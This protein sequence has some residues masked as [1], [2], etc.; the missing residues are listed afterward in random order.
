MVSKHTNFRSD[1]IGLRALA[2]TLVMLAHFQIP[3]FGFGFIGV[4]IFFVISGFL[5]TRIL[6]RD[7]VSSNLKDPSKSFLSLTS[8][9]LRRI[10]RLLPAAFTV[11][12]LVNVV[13][14]FLLNSEARA[15]L[16]EN[17]KWSLLFFANV[18]FLRSE[19]DYFQQDSEPS[20]LLHFWSLSIEEQ[21]YFVWPLLFL[22]AASLNKFKFRKKYFRFNNRLL[23]LISVA[24]MASFAFLQV[25]FQTA[26]AEAYFSIFTRAWE[27]GVGGFFGVLAFHKR[28]E[29]V[30]SSLELYTPLIGSLVFSAFVMT[31]S[32][33][34]TYVAIPV[35]AT[36]FFL[37]AGQD[38]H[39]AKGRNIGH[40][41][42][43][44]K[45]VM[46]IGTISYSLYL[47]HWP[48]FVV[49][50]S[51][52]T[53]Y[54]TFARL[55]LIPISIF[56]A[57]LLW[58]FVEIPFQ[59]IPL[60]KTG[61]WD[62][63]IFNFL[64]IRKYWIGT[65][66]FILIGSIYLVTYPSVS[67]NFFPGNSVDS[68]VALDPN[69]KKYSDYQSNLITNSQ[70]LAEEQTQNNDLSLVESDANV[71]TLTN[72]HVAN[73]KKAIN[74]TTLSAQTADMLKSLKKNISPFE[75]SPCTYQDTQIPPNCSISGTS[76]RSKSVALIG[77]SK[78]SHFAQ[79]LINY[80]TKKGWKIEPMI[81]DGCILS[82]PELSMMKNCLARSQWV[83]N[84]IA[85]AK[86]DLV[87]SAEWP[88]NRISEYKSNFYKSIQQNSNY[89]IVLK[90]NSKTQGPINCISD[91]NTYKLECQI[92]N[93]DL[94]PDWRA[95]LS[96]MDTLKSKNTSVI[97][98]QQWICV[99]NI[100][101]YVFDD[102]LVTRDGSHLTYSFVKKIESL[103]H[104]SVDSVL[105][106]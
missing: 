71:A 91:R 33:W 29:T 94:V 82:A 102:V 92:V 96:Y 14:F 10:R 23:L 50:D 70:S 32:N 88:A 18:A 61:F 62:A 103:I 43:L 6:Y 15:N 54:G 30:F 87:I 57:F 53:S 5:I 13:S 77:D 105:P 83:L 69:L 21:F 76:V 75:A 9:Y 40:P 8:F 104:A 2:V 66:T 64:K 51:L 17:S 101:P 39:H 65:L 93:K 42:I 67:Y 24:S 45:P 37:F 28:R 36:G 35:F 12:A 26:P 55:C 79:P 74:L 38:N 81:M 100:C 47:V 78:M 44:S 41:K 48:I 58:K 90:T 25:G 22:I 20:M 86:Y 106:S 68:R 73:L 72:D 63:S 1:I 89:L 95:A 4:D 49:F 99:E 46:F 7:F 60:P 97:N 84:K 3:F 27:L 98:S 80:F 85:T 59:S 31:D 56:L 19:S 52:D 34:A 16:L 11:I